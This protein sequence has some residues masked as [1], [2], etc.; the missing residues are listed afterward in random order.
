MRLHLRVLTVEAPRGPTIPKR[1]KRAFLCYPNSNLFRGRQP[2]RRRIGLKTFC[3]LAILVCASRFGVPSAAQ[4]LPTTTQE[5]TA[6]AQAQPEAKPEAP[7]APSQTSEEEIQRREQSQRVLGVLP[8]FSVT[9][10]QNAPPLT[11]RGKFRLFGK[12]AFDPITVGVAAIQAGAGQARNNF[13]G[14]GQGAAGYGKRFG[15]AFGDEVSAGFFSNFFYP[16]LFK[17]DPRYFRLGE[18]GFKRRFVYALRQ[19][20]ICHTDSGK[21]SFAWENVLGAFSSGGL[22]NLYYPDSDRGAGLTMSR[23]GIAI[24]YNS[25]AG[26]VNEFYPD[27][28]RKLIHRR[29]SSNQ[30][31]PEGDPAH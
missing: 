28:H 17:E 20:F 18:G 13:P 21:R 7:P 26:V 10:R 27:L 6:G 8:D 24:V 22:S 25:I 11:R 16:V 2:L 3:A 29:P 4:Q 15:A 14:Y 23:A 19:E 5:P 31:P 1:P 30:P 9:N 12:I